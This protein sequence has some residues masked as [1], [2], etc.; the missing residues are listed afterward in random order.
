MTELLWSETLHNGAME[1]SAAS[2]NIARIAALLVSSVT[3]HTCHVSAQRDPGHGQ[4]SNVDR[5]LIQS[6]QRG[7]AVQWSRAGYDSYDVAPSARLLLTAPADVAM[8]CLKQP[9]APSYLI[10]TRA[11][12]T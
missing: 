2:S 10:Q 7:G 4:C 3:C 12:D 1:M 9:P 6:Q 11:T 5:T 8:D